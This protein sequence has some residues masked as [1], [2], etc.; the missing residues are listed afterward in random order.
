MYVDL[1]FTPNPTP[2]SAILYM[3]PASNMHS[4]S[5]HPASKMPKSNDLNVFA[6]IVVVF[7][8]IL[9]TLTVKLPATL[10]LTLTTAFSP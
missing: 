7:T 6:A 3:L 4:T 1:G 5:C 2:F 9:S 8:E 10:V